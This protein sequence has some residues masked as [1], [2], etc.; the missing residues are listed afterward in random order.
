MQIGYF[1]TL[2][3]VTSCYEPVK[4]VLIET[5]FKLNDIKHSPEAFQKTCL[6]ALATI[7][8]INFHY[9]TNYLPQ[10]ITILD[11]APA[12]DFYCFLRLP[13]YILHPY[14]AKSFDE[15]DLLEQ[16]EVIFCDNWNLGQPDTQ[17]KNRAPNVR[18]YI[19]KQLNL[20]LNKMEEKSL[21][22]S[23]EE[24]VKTIVRNWFKETLKTDP[25]H[26]FDPLKIDLQ[27]LKIN[28][29]SISWL[30]SAGL[31][32]L[33]TADIICVPDFLQSWGLID[34]A[35]YANTIGSIP[36]LSWVPTQILG[37][38]IWGTLCTG[39][40][41]QFINAAHDLRNGDLSAEE[42]ND[43]KWMMIS[44][45]AECLYCT[46]NLLK[47]DAQVINCLAL[48]A[49]SLGLISFFFASKASFFNLETAVGDIS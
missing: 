31:F 36:L 9:N 20:L 42:A 15:Y 29:K 17:G 24:E 48:I 40:I 39:F 38:W 35:P 1:D 7:R 41:L 28:L 26:G 12:F 14:C 37:D 10:L 33:A 19:E 16:L 5:I 23:T 25:I 34:L 6:I 32:S 44:S 8:A 27:N 18:Q 47:S 4:R 49:K 22:F 45:L 21:D 11:T 3:P 2:I 43:A 13:R 46:S 30:E